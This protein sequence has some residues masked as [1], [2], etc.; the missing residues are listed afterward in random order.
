MKKTPTLEC[1]FDG[2]CYPKNPYGTMGMG[3]C[4]N[5]M[6]IELWKCSHTIPAGKGNSNNVAEYLA[7]EYILDYLINQK[8][9][10]E[11]ILIK[12]DSKLVIEQ[13]SGY[14]KI[15]NGMYVPAALRCKKKVSILQ[16]KNT[17]N[18]KW[19]PREQNSYCDELSGGKN[20]I[21]PNPRFT[22]D[23]IQEYCVANN[24]RPEDLIAAHKMLKETAV[25][26]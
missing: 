6:G 25:N 2:A 17:V 20:F 15:K 1:F 14:F 10:G 23:T 13:M 3:A 11:T 12:G 7:L 4:I 24:C 5:E 19:I 18:F 9:H 26:Y 16:Q 21:L 8:A 22:G